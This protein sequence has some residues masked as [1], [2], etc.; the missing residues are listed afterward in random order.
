MDTGSRGKILSGVMPIICRKNTNLKQLLRKMQQLKRENKM[1]TSHPLTISPMLTIITEHYKNRPLSITPF[2][3][4]DVGCG[5]GKWGMLIREY[6][7]G[8]WYGRRYE[9]KDTWKVHLVGVEP[10]GRYITDV[11]RYHYD[12]IIYRDIWEAIEEEELKDER[13]DIILLSDVIEHMIQGEGLKL[14]SQLKKYLKLTGII[15]LSTPTQFFP[16]GKVDGCEWE[17]H[18]C[19][20]SEDDI[21]MLDWYNCKSIEMADDTMIAILTPKEVNA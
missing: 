15:L 14:L 12:R 16:Q 3:I 8:C 7:D 6:L 18:K 21:K 2:S 19:L 10:F 13:F 9:N 1:P 4:L 17:V 11:H 5:N 20:W